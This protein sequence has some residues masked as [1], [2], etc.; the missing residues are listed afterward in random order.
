VTEKALRTANNLKTTQIKVGQKLKI[1][2][3][4]SAPTPVREA[5]NVVP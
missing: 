2:A 3:S 4:V 5:T 1:P